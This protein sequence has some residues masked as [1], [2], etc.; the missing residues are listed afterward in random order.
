MQV[1]DQKSPLISFLSAPD[2]HIWKFLLFLGLL[3]LCFGSSAGTQ[4]VSR[5]ALADAFIQVTSFVG[6]TLLIFYYL[7][8]RLKI[9]FGKVMKRHQAWQPLLAACAGALPGCG[10][11]IIVITQFSLG[12]IGFGAVVAVLTST[13]G[14]AAFLLL[15]KAPETALLVFSISITAGTLSGM[16]VDKIHGPEFL[17][18]KRIS[19]QDFRIRCGKAI[20][21]SKGFCW[22]WYILLSLSIPLG[23][24]AAFQVDTDSWFGPLSYLGPT[25]IIGLI[26]ALTCFWVW[27][28]LPDKGLSMVNL[29][30]HPA[31]RT[32]V[33]TH[34]RII[35]DATFITTMV[36]F[37]FL[38]FEL[39]IHW[40]GWDITA[41][42]RLSIPL[43]IALAL[44]IGFL[45]GCG[46]QVIVTTLFLNGL[47]PFPALL[48]NAI[49]NDGDA[50]FPAIAL[51]PRVA[52]I[53][54]LYTAIPAV[55]LSYGWYYFM[56]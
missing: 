30:A 23:I 47:I 2:Q 28:M 37:A 34:N 32:H 50:L 36:I 46:P 18:A 35:L 5:G 39:T 4:D 42:S 43:V 44:L 52:V 41:F 3:Y 21:Y 31:C 27:V 24:G 9:D 14:D 40:T 29:M 22:Y 10:A 53:A 48:A 38:A 13:M 51:A 19:W 17:R 8:V 33:K 49:S 1:S 54:T 12:R 16:V 6:L 15:A 7:E 56:L 11:A 45:P 55:I 20:A 25:Q 26:G